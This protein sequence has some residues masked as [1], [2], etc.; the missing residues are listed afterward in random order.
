MSEQTRGKRARIDCNMMNPVWTSDASSSY[1]L[2]SREQ[3][4]L[5]QYLGLSLMAPDPNTAQMNRGLLKLTFSNPFLMHAS[6]AVALAYDQCLAGHRYPQHRSDVYYHWS[7]SL[8]IFSKGLK[9]PVAMM[10]KDALWGTAAALAVLT[11]AF[12]DA[13]TPEESWPLYPSARPDLQWLNMSQGKMTL[14]DIANP[15]RPESIFSV[16]IDT[17]ALMNSSMPSKG[18]ARMPMSLA[19]ICF[20]TVESTSDTSPYFIPAHAVSE[21]LVLP[22][23][24]VEIGHTERFTQS[25]HGSFKDLLAN[26]DPTALLLLFLWYRKASHNIW[27]IRSRASVECPAILTYL[28]QHH[29]HHND[30]LT[31][32]MDEFLVECPDVS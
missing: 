14:W 27:W 1:Q 19:A 4:L 29:R 16:M 25:I 15:L 31:S 10:N 28:K 22:D 23:C 24:D 32:L 5:H 18:L 12:P 17:Y 9:E 11:F 3:H 6:L 13:N 7:Q 26:K 21:I 2:T 20:L 8:L 30:V